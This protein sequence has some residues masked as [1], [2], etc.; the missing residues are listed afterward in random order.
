METQSTGL[1]GSETGIEQGQVFSTVDD[2]PPIRRS[3]VLSGWLER[4][5]FHPLLAAFFLFVLTFILFQGI[6][7]IVALTI[8]VAQQGVPDPAGLMAMLESSTGA[9]LV[10][11]TVGQFVGLAIPVLIWTTLHTKQSGAFL[12]IGKPDSVLLGL[13]VFAL[14]GLLP[15]IQWL[16]EINASL[17][18]PDF[19]S[20]LEAAQL[21]LIE[22]I[23]SSGIWIGSTIFA[24][25]ITPAL[26]EELLFRGYLQRQFERSF[27][28]VGGIVTTGVLFGL[29]HFRLSQ[30]IPLAAL[31]IFLGWLAWRTGSLWVPILIHF[32]NN[33]IAILVSSFATS[34]PEW[35]IEDLENLPA[36]WPV[37]LGGA[38][39]LAGA[40]VLMN[41]RVVS[42]DASSIDHIS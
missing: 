37:V 10:G 4:H 42:I 17:P 19:L 33:G 1:S 32:I 3:V 2:G 12:R 35:G 31:G 34:N 29:Y 9:L 6:A 25:A 40:I 15:V 39:L 38:L 8:I 14:A 11:N 7:A 5:G 21:E 27:G 18:I 36:P 23:L 26:C 41:R 16:G 22:R 20:E 30:A 24:L 28:I 13:S